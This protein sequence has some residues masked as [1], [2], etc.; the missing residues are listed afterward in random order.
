MKIVAFKEHGWFGG[1]DGSIT[2]WRLWDHL[3]RAYGVSLQLVDV[4]EDIHVPPNSDL[5][6]V[7]EEGVG[8]LEDLDRVSADDSIYVFGRTGLSLMGYPHNRSIRI[9]TPNPI[10]LFGVEAAAI[11]LSRLA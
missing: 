3:C 5:V 7:D 11:V 10:C 8:L 9:A 1:D 4:W 2:E 6:V